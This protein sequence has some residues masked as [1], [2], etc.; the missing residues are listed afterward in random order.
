MWNSIITLFQN[1]IS[2]KIEIYKKIKFLFIGGTTALV[3]F[4]LIYLTNGILKLNHNL[5]IS[6]SFFS[7]MIYHFMMNKM[8]VFQEKKLSRLKY[9]IIQYLILS[10]INYLINLGVVNLLLLFKINIYIGVAAAT[11]ITMLLTYF[12]MNRLIFNKKAAGFINLSRKTE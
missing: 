7:A 2:D 1:I 9:Q 12:I 10:F 4:S 11:I 3:N 5:S 6:I 8:F